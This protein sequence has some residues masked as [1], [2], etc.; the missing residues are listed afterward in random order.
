VKDHVVTAAAVVLPSF[1]FSSGSG[2]DFDL[3]SEGFDPSS[4][5]FDPSSE[6]FAARFVRLF[7][8]P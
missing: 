3:S 5:G 2:W 8:Y 7:F 1:S 4:E 6:G